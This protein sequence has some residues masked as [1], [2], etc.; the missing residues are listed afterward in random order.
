[1]SDLIKREVGRPTVF[2]EEVLK[3][4]EEAFSLGCTDKE[5]CLLANISPASLYNYQNENPEFIERKEL[6]KQDPILKARQ[7]VIKAL[8]DPE[9]AEWYLERKRKGEFS[10]AHI[11]ATVELPKP[12]VD[13]NELRENNRS[14]ENSQALTK[15]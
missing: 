14:Q 12:L 10:P 9:H 13:L 1:M 8:D 7:T 5:A 15:N 4:L 2:T 11:N 6:L 3:K